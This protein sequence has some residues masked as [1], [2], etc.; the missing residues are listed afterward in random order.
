MAAALAF[1]AEAQTLILAGQDERAGELFLKASECYRQ[2]WELAPPASYGRLV[3]ML[4]AAILG[5]AAGQQ[6]G[7]QAEYA[8]SQLIKAPADSPTAAYAR[9][10]A[11]LVEGDDEA[12]RTSAQVM[13]GSS[14]AFD[15]AA[16]AIVAVVARDAPACTHAIQRIVDDFEGR[17]EHLTGVAIADTA[18]MFERLAKAR[19]VSADVASALLPA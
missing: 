18:L 11:Q 14:G 5:G 4:K 7:Q 2:S 16:E 19:G 1:E 8:L 15:R 10:L 12:A 17:T 9:A 3:G 6:A 13:R